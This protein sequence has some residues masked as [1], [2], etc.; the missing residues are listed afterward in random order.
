MPE[1][2]LEEVTVRYP[3]S[4]AAALD[5]VSLRV[6]A[7]ER[8]AVTGPSGAGKSTLLLVLLGLVRPE[9]GRVLVDGTDLAELD[10]E[11]WRARLGWVPQ[12]PHLF[13]A[14]VADNIRLG[15]P[16]ADD[17]RVVEAARAAAA[18][19]FVRALPEG[20]ATVLGERGAGLSA[21]QRQRVAI[22]RAYLT[23][24]PVMLLDEPTARL[25]LHSERVLVDAAARLLADRT[26]VIVAHRPALLS[27][28]DRV[29]RLED[30]HLTTDLG[31]G[32]GAADGAGGADVVRRGREAVA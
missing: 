15:A 18:D 21:G 19:E 6:A 1:I 25:D 27:A 24:A 3:G 9:S 11:A 5:R 16:D 32:V 31:L 28:A 14:S 8:V 30:G 10:A 22:A 20:Y 4:E 29:V 12:R 2:V 13:A 23:G 7:G 17:E 26:A